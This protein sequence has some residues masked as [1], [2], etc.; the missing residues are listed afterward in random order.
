VIVAGVDDRAGHE[1]GD[2]QMPR[3]G[4][5]LLLVAEPLVPAGAGPTTIDCRRMQAR[6]AGDRGG[7]IAVAEIVVVAEPALKPGGILWFG[8]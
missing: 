5:A 3:A 1:V 8:S 7:G 6:P 4:G 2:E